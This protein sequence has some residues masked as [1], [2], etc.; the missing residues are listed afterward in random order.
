MVNV[1][2]EKRSKK[3]HRNTT[4]SWGDGAGDSSGGT[5]MAGRVQNPI[6]SALLSLQL[7]FQIGNSIT[8]GFAPSDVL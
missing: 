1:L 3:L 6:P 4:V 7:N 8:F 5:P 2:P